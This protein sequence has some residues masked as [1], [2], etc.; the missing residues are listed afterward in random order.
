MENP[1]SLGPFRVLICGQ[2]DYRNYEAILSWVEKLPPG[3]VVIHGGAPG[4]DILAGQAAMACGLDVVVFE[5][6]WAQFGRA[7]GPIRNKRMLTI[8][9]PDFV[10]AFYRK[11]GIEKSKGTNNMVRQSR[12]YQTPVMIVEDP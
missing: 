2:R 12:K 9:K 6:Q 1:E 4:A 11:G 3:S 8:G 10:W 5:A 7:A